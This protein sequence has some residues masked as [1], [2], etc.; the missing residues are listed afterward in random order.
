MTH[1]GSGIESYVV[2][3]IGA[4]RWLTRPETIIRSAWRG[5]ARNTSMPNR[6]MSNRGVPVAI[7]S[8]AQQARPMVTGHSEVRR[9]SPTTFSIVVSANPAGTFSSIPMSFLSP[10]RV[11]PGATRTRTAP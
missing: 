9:A 6:E 2:R 1:L 7:I 5:E 4:I 10:S 3:T 8:I 11:R